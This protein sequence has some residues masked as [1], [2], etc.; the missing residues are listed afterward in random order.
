MSGS[1]NLRPKTSRRP[2]RARLGIDGYVRLLAYINTTPGTIL[3]IAEG[4]GIGRD[5]SYKLVGRFYACGWLHVAAWRQVRDAKALPVFAFGKGVDAPRPSKTL[6]GHPIGASVA[7]LP[8]VSVSP[9]AIGLCA[10]LDELE[11]ECNLP[12]LTA[13]TGLNRQTAQKALDALVEH[14]LAHV[15]LLLP[16]GD[17][18][19]GAYMR[20]WKLGA[21]KNATMPSR[22]DIQRA[23]GKRYREA[24]KARDF[25]AS[26]SFALAGAAN[27][28][29]AEQA[30]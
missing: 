15:A 23:N 26:V 24:R 9:E 22:R 17:G 12:E 6:T 2:M 29:Q 25:Q 1:T 16:R 5:T 7:A 14:K 30:A 21:G 10:L 4:F 19:G 3:Q 28:P 13:S 11:S 18:C 27:Q 20:H 8:P